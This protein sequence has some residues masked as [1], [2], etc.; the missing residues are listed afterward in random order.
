MTTRRVRGGSSLSSFN[1]EVLIE[2]FLESSMPFMRKILAGLLYCAMLKVW[3]TD[4]RKINLYW[5][6][7]KEEA[8]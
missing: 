6:D 5:D 3:E 1:F 8:A 2:C 7:V 4:R